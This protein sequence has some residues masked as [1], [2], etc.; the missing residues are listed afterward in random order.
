[1]FQP[2][3]NSLT[4]PELETPQPTENLS[5][6]S[7]GFLKAAGFLLR[8]TSHDVFGSGELLS[9]VEAGLSQS[10]DAAAP[11]CRLY[12]QAEVNITYLW[13]PSRHSHLD[14][15]PVILPAAQVNRPSPRSLLDEPSTLT[16]N[17]SLPSLRMTPRV[18]YSRVD[19]ARPIT[20]ISQG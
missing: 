4:D 11:Q 14:C 9:V 20:D 2:L 15:H 1:M 18:R 17:A 3:P 5:A 12:A 8:S 10:T 13:N 6:T 16:R 19:G 7:M